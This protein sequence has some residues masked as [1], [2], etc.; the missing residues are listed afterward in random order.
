MLAYALVSLGAPVYLGR[1]GIGSPL[2][3]V[4][5]AVGLLSMAFVFWANWLPQLIPGGIFPAL[6]GAL[7]WLPYVFLAWTAIGLVWYLVV[8]T[9]RP[10]IASGLGSRF[11]SAEAEPASAEPA[12]AAP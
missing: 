5:G 8:R 11:E 6:T 2:V 7:V 4:V 9:T 1:L 10:H 12:V 3:A